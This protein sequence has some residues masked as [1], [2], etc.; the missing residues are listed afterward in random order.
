MFHVFTGF[1][2]FTVI[3][4]LQK[5]LPKLFWWVLLDEISL[6]SSSQIYSSILCLGKGTKNWLKHRIDLKQQHHHDIT[7]CSFYVSM[8][9]GSLFGERVKKWQG[10]GRERAWASRQTS[11]TVVPWHPLRIRS[12]CKLLLARTLTVDMFDLHRFFGRQ[13][14]D[15]NNRW[16]KGLLIFN[17]ASS[18]TWLMHS[19]SRN[20]RSCIR[21]QITPTRNNNRRKSICVSQPLSMK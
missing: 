11:G 5:S 7:P 16:Q 6:I 4:C 15:L 1:L 13:V 14:F 10:D 21:R 8:W 3:V 2:S 19:F 20:E 12:W 17:M 18:G 9:T